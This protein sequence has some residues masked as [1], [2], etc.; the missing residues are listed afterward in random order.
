MMETTTDRVRQRQKIVPFEDLPKIRERFRDKTIIHCHGAF[1]LVH[2][3]HLIHFEEAKGLGDLLVV[4]ITADAYITKKRSVTFNEEH[5]ARQVAALEIVD[6]VA[7]VPEPTA[8]SA[9]EAL[10]PEVYVKGPEYANL[11]LDKSRSIFYEM[12]ILE[13]YG[14]RI[15]FTAGETFS[16][17]K[18]AHFL[19]AAPEA[20][21]RDPLLRNERVLFRDI[22]QLGFR[23]EELKSFLARASDLRVC[24]LG[25]TIIDEW[26]DI[27][28]TNLSTQSR[29]VAGLETSRVKQL[30][31]VGII[32]RH[33]AGFV[34]DV[35]CFTN[36]LSG[37]LPSNIRV[38]Q[39]TEGELVET[40][41]VDRESGHP[42]FKSKSL[43]LAD[44][45][46]EALPDFDAYD[47]VLIADYGHGLLDAAAMNQRIAERRSAFVAA[48]AQVNSSNYGY[49]LPTKYRGADYYSLNRTE[50]E[51]CLHERNLPLPE[52]VA[53]TAALLESSVLS[54]T[55]GANGAMV[56]LEQE[57]FALPPLSVSVVDTIGCGDAYFALS[58]LAARLA[59]SARLVALTGSIGAAA[60]SQRR[61]NESPVT[62][63]E[64]M[65]IGKIVI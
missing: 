61:C 46:H 7:V 15:H 24:V 31:G 34:R 17:T 38:T 47:V 29:C 11:V 5:R 14:G 32:A 1:D 18:L 57:R 63:Q 12:R 19:L 53:R 44:V 52:L 40:R 13:G 39:L 20:A 43:G 35:H 65:T 36:A 55:D 33:L 56:K 54:V 4:T 16:S 50:A 48:M 58:S 60:M 49:N 42:L 27:S 2:I 26:V 64:F 10:R 51:L 45:R 37:D 41:F 23:L 28:V 22:S 25:E 6:Y 59:L 62:E 8:L 9:I 3:G 21:Q 30:G